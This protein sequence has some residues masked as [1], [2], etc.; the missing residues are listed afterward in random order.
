MQ[1]VQL[2]IDQTL[3]QT[4]LRSVQPPMQIKQHQADL[5]ISQEH[6]NLVEISTT[7]RRLYIDQTEAFADANL[8]TPLRLSN[9]FY[10]RIRGTVMNYVAKTAREGEQLK[11]I[12]NGNHA[13]THIAAQRGSRPQKQANI[14]YMPNSMSK[15]SFDYQP[16]EV[17]I[18]ARKSEANIHVTPQKPEIDIPKWGV[19]I[20]L[21]QKNQI[22]FQA[23][24]TNV[25][26]GL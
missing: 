25:D 12:E 20:Y 1:Q 11:K 23:V 16:S 10:Q 15:V 2:H 14:A 26:R 8:K 19:D 24:G 6:T 7:A 17:H 4:G 13:I 22:A 21:Q 3:A 5:Q 18:R 9:E